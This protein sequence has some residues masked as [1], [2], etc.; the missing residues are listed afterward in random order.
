MRQQNFNSPGT[1]DTSS[2]LQSGTSCYHYIFN[3]ILD[4]GRFVYEISSR[5]GEKSAD[6]NILRHAG[7]LYAAFQGNV[8]YPASAYPEKADW[9]VQFLLRQLQVVTLKNNHFKCIVE[10]GE[11]KLG[12]NS[13]TMIAL[14]E[15]YKLTKDKTDLQTIQS[16][17]AF[18]LYMQEE[19]G[20]FK[21]KLLVSN[22]TFSFFESVYYPGQAIL[23]L[24]RLYKADQNKQW[25]AAAKRA[26]AYLVRNP[27]MDSSYPRGNNH[28]FAIALSELCMLAPNEDYYAELQLIINST[29]ASITRQSQLNNKNEEQISST[30]MATR[31]EAVLAGIELESYLESTENTQYWSHCMQEGLKFCLKHLVT[32]NNP[33][34]NA[35]LIGGIKKKMKNSQI[36]IDYVQHTLSVITGVLNLQRESNSISVATSKGIS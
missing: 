9:A 17:A 12:G 18:L 28:W 15:K 25:L 2:L 8:L 35:K 36:R 26:A 34:I 23:A 16:L 11:A 19:D 20:K 29:A 27:V 33:N 21:S 24:V 5:T 32:E 14:L 30:A 31:C 6:Y 22:L 4:D 13:L 1:V 7:A 10:G 3:A